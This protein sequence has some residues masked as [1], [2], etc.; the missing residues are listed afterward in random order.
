[1]IQLYVAPGCPACVRVIDFLEE[2]AI[3]FVEKPISLWNDCDTRRELV[4]LA[5]RKQVP[6]LHD[7]IRDVR[8]HESLDIID[9][10]GE[11]YGK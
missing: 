9:Y 3:P 5:G 7:P 6:F 4:E 10:I 1:M 11:H 8:M 2:Q